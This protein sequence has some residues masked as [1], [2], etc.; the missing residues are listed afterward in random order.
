MGWGRNGSLEDLVNARPG[1]VST[2]NQQYLE[3][4]GLNTLQCVDK[5]QSLYQVDLSGENQSHL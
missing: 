5:Y 2:K 4:P 3:M 1:Q